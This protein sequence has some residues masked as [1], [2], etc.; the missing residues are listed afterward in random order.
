[1]W[2]RTIGPIMVLILGVL[3]SPF[4]ANAQKV[5]FVV[6]HASPQKL[7]TLDEI[8]DDTPLS[9]LGRERAAVLAGRLKDAGITAIYTSDLVRAVQ[10][11]E[12][13][14]D[15]LKL[16][17]NKLPR[18][19]VDALL[20]RIRD[21]H[22]E[23]KVLIVGHW[24]TIPKIINALGHPEEVKMERSEFDGLYTVIPQ[25][26]GPPLVLLIRY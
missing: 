5:I 25:S 26:K 14:A 4:S 9:E 3:W 19:D 18:N 1:M 2:Y 23:D 15:T 21:Q 16:P 10:M 6:R 8:R 24:N 22:P 11:A 12:P 20:S 13:L 7:L 17:I